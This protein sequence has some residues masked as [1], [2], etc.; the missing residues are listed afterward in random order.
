MGKTRD[1]DIYS[2]KTKELL[3]LYNIEILKLYPKF[4]ETCLG[5]NK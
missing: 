5:E 1:G 3:K 4:L 2:E